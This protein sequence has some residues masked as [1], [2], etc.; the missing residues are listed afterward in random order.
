MENVSTENSLG[1]VFQLMKH[2]PNTL[3]VVFNIFVQYSLLAVRRANWM[4]KH[5]VNKDAF[6]FMWLFGRL[7]AVLLYCCLSQVGE[8]IAHFGH[9]KKVGIGKNTHVRILGT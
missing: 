1:F 3:H 6:F 7:D 4:C 8:W 5:K 9:Q 2:G